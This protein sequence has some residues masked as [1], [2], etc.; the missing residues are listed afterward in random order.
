M[1]NPF[2]TKF[3]VSGTIPFQFSEQSEN[4]D[5]IQEKAHRYPIC[6]IA[7]PHGSGKSTLL[8][9]LLKRYDESGEHLR[10]LFF[11]NQYRC[12]P[13]EIPFPKDQ[14][15]FVDGFEQ[16]SLKDRLWLLFQ[17]KRLILTVHRPIWFVPVL[18]RT[19]PEFS[20]FVQ[21]IRQMVSDLPEESVLRRVYERSGGNFRNA[22]FELYD[23][24]EKQQKNM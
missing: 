14:I 15:L 13:N 24:W 4:I 9:T 23:Q 3:W 2:S 6:Q 1:L 16:L 18:Y 8:L 5:T 20:I 22:F 11:N 17:S 21:V 7:G 12:I 19:K 10:Y